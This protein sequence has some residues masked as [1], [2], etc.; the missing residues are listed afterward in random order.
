[1]LDNPDVLPFSPVIEPT[2]NLPDSSTVTIFLTDTLSIDTV[3]ICKNESLKAG[4]YSIPFDVFSGFK[5]ITGKRAVKLH[6][7]AQ[8]ILNKIGGIL[9]NRFRATFF[10]LLP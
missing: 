5:D 6:F 2:F 8:R 1:M 10:I 3:W 9:E 4:L 7:E